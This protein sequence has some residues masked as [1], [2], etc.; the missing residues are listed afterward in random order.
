MPEPQVVGRAMVRYP[1][2]FYLYIFVRPRGI[3]EHLKTIPIYGNIN[4]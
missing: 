3:V 4:I 2:L 1:T